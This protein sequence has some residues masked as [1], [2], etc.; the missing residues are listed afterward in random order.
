[1]TFFIYLVNCFLIRSKWDFQL[2][3]YKFKHLIKKGLL[4][5]RN[6]N[7]IYRLNKQL[8][9]RFPGTDIQ[10][11]NDFKKQKYKSNSGTMLNTQKSCKNY[12]DVYTIQWFKQKET[13][14]YIRP[15]VRGCINFL[16]CFTHQCSFNVYSSLSFRNIIQEVCLKGEN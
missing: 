6:C 5:Q 12:L 14:S 9:V 7:L 13:H 1:M 3:N 10:T 2:T 15:C 8:C 11:T 16:Q 4:Y